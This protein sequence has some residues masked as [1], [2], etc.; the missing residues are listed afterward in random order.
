MGENRDLA[1]SVGGLVDSSSVGM[2]LGSVGIGIREVDQTLHAAL[3]FCGRWQSQGDG[4]V[5]LSGVVDLAYHSIRRLQSQTQTK[6]VID[7][8]PSSALGEGWLCQTLI[9][10][11]RTQW[12]VCPT[13]GR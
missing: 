6:K 5:A 9:L 4:T 1:N 12:Y 10:D 8:Q 3:L 13:K 11:T 2:H 7:I